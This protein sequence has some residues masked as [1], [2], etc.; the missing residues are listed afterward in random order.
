LVPA[1]P[2]AVTAATTEYAVSGVREHDLK[3]K[4]PFRAILDADLPGARNGREDTA[5]PAE[6]GPSNA[7]LRKVCKTKQF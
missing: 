2:T 3:V 7:T 5:Q 1:K 6:E 4:A